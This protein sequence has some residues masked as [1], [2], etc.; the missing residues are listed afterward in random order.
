[1]LKKIFKNSNKILIASV[2]TVYLLLVGFLPFSNAYAAGAPQDS[3]IKGVNDVIRILNDVVKWVYA[4]FFIIAVLFILFAAFSFLTSEGNPEKAKE[5]QKQILYAA[6]AIA[7]ALLSV[8]F[9]LII[10]TF[11]RYGT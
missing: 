7:I 10:D 5:A 6:I 11:L 9:S 8:G 3:P 1:M 4:I 2:F